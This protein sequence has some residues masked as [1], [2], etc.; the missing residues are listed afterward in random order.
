MLYRSCFLLLTFCHNGSGMRNY[1][2]LTHP[3]SLHEYKTKLGNKPQG[4]SKLPNHRI[5]TSLE[6]SDM[7]QESTQLR[8]KLERKIVAKVV[9]NRPFKSHSLVSLASPS[10]HCHQL[11]HPEWNTC[12]L[13]FLIHAPV[14]RTG[15]LGLEPSHLCA[16][17]N[18]P[19]RT[20]HHLERNR[21]SPPN[22]LH[23]PTWMQTSISNHRTNT[24]LRHPPD[25]K[26]Q[27]R[28]M[29]VLPLQRN[30]REFH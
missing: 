11:K 25:D 7:W 27:S 17:D 21:A 26:P 6:S 30:A 29:D 16:A 2:R 20:L 23:G 4:L 24:Q 15:H 22:P 19:S 12:R 10:P 18:T 3:L 9:N 14:A 13:L 5:I 8:F 28:Q 1:P